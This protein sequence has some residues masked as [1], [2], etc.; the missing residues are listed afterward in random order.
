MAQW[1]LACVNKY[2]IQLICV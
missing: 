2:E 1:L